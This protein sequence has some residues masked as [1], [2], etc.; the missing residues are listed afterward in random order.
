VLPE[1]Q[2]H[3]LIRSDRAKT[4]YRGVCFNRGRY[5]AVCETSPCLHNQLGRFDTAEDAA[6][7]YLQ[8]WETKHPKGLPE[9]Q[10][11]LLIR[12]DKSSTGFKGVRLNRGRY[13]AQ[14]TT[15]PCRNKSL[16]VFDTPEEA[17]REYLQHRLRHDDDEEVN[18]E[19]VSSPGPIRVRTWTQAMDRNGLYMTRSS[20]HRNGSK[21][22]YYNVHEQTNCT[23]GGSSRFAAN[24]V[25]CPGRKRQRIGTANSAVKAAHIVAAHIQ[26]HHSKPRDGLPPTSICNYFYTAE[27]KAA[28][29]QKLGEPFQYSKCANPTCGNSEKKCRK[30]VTAALQF[31]HLVAT[32]NGGTK[33][34]C[35]SM[36]SEWGQLAPVWIKIGDEDTV[37][38]KWREEK[39]LCQML[40]IDCHILK[41]GKDRVEYHSS[42]RGGS[43]A[44]QFANKK[45]RL[46]LHGPP[47]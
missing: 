43:A 19:K 26:S 17:A 3:L 41:N 42:G 8:H 16:G 29:I 22:G 10:E 39:R 33:T 27:D 7:S 4:G 11:H 6:Q 36:W 40:C 25:H 15:A 18:G 46:S 35:L 34:M 20:V 32:K 14:C 24:C 13:Q 30:G 31:D 12:S 45:R 9:V 1:V 38:Q 21:T 47:E 2:E 23:E 37:T 5:Q 44:M 28:V